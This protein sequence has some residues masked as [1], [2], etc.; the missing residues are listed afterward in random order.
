MGIDKGQM[1]TL[2]KAAVAMEDLDKLTVHAR[3]EGGEMR[4]SIHFKSR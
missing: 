4:T 1:E 3:R 2:R